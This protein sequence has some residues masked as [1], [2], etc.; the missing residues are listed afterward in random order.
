M[1]EVE[2]ASSCAH[3]LNLVREEEEVRIE[4]KCG[5]SSRIRVAD[6]PPQ[7]MILKN[8]QQ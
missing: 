8:V 4:L 3:V 5:S 2:G 6:H 1:A 7:W